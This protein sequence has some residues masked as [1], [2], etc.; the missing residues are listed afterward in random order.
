L[1]SGRARIFYKKNKKQKASP[2]HTLSGECGE[3]D[4]AVGERD[5]FAL[6]RAASQ[7]GLAAT[8]LNVRRH[9]Q[10]EVKAAQNLSLSLQ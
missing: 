9:L 8:A 4:A 1:P 10:E 7:L 5:Q 2:R 3:V 6:P